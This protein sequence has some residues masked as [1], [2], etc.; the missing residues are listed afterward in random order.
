MNIDIMGINEMRCPNSGKIARGKHAVYYSGSSD[1][2]HQ[3]GVRMILKKHITQYVN[4]FVPISERI[5]LIQLETYPVNIT[6][7]QVYAPTADK[8]KNIIEQFYDFLEAT[9]TRIR[10]EVL[11]IMGDFNSKIGRGICGNFVGPFDLGGGNERGE[12]LNIFCNKNKL[13][14]I[15]LVGLLDPPLGASPG[16]R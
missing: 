11:I 5:L 9:I 14:V 6:I 10:K 8:S 13:V 7:I 4:N 16:G 2:K 12:R 15:T 3:H 1:N